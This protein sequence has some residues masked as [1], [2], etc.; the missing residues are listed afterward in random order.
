MLWSE[1]TGVGWQVSVGAWKPEVT[2]KWGAP[3]QVVKVMRSIWFWAHSKG[4][5]EGVLSN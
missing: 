4:G 1:L 2:T 5:A 3:R